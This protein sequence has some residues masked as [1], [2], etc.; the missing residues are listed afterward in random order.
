MT[1][2][3][4]QRQERLEM[5]RAAI[6]VEQRRKKICERNT[7]SGADGKSIFGKRVVRFR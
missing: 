3:P 1:L 2:T 4:Q 5:L 6:A 7:R